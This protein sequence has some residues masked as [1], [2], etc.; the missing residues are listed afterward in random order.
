MNYVIRN[1]DGDTYI[2][3]LTDEKLEERLADGYYGEST[4]MARLPKGI[5]SN[6]WDESILIIRGDIITKGKK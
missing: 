1:S 5:D 2:D 3:E 6:Y 4:G